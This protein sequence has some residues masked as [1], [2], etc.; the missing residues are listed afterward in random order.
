MA[1]GQGR[2]S[3]ASSETTPR[4]ARPRHGWGSV[5]GKH[6]RLWF[7]WPGFESRPR[8]LTAKGILRKLA[9]VLLVLSG[10]TLGMWGLGATVENVYPGRL[11]GIGMMLLMPVAIWTALKV[12]PEGGT[13]GY[14]DQNI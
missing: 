5:A 8:P 2:A 9:A 3:T 11:V 4:F 1:P 13:S 7:C 10:A 12:T 14:C 6:S